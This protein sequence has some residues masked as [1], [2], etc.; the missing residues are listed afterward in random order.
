M[1][2]LGMVRNKS[3]TAGHVITA[4]CLF[5]ALALAGGRPAKAAQGVVTGNI[6]TLSEGWNQPILRLVLDAPFVNPDSCPSTDGYIVA[7]TL[8]ANSQIT[9][10]AISA[11]SMKQRVTL[12]LDGCYQGRPNVIG[13]LV[14]GQ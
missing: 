5:A 2:L 4:C 10:M 14:G 11:Y 3:L 13:F 6:I 8:P 7:D 9:A 12:I 1:G